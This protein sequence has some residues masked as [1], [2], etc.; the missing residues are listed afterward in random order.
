MLLGTSQHGWLNDQHAETSFCLC[1][2]HR[3]GRPGSSLG[4]EAKAEAIA[5]R[6]MGEA[7]KLCEGIDHLFSTPTTGADLRCAS[8]DPMVIENHL[9]PT[10]YH[11]EH[12]NPESKL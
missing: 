2:C 8:T 5:M 1:D 11:R 4:T 12:T 10:G 3:P 9:P 7:A 6:E